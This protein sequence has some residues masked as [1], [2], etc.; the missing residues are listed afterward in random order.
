MIYEYNIKTDREGFYNITAQVEEA[1]KK[2][3]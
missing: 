3:G 2:S 1:V